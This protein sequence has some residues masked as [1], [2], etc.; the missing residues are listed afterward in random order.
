MKLYNIL[1]VLAVLILAGCAPAENQPPEIAITGLQSEYIVGTDVMYSVGATDDAGLVS[2]TIG[3]QH[4]DESGTQTL[5]A[6]P[7]FIDCEGKRTCTHIVGPFTSAETGR[8]VI[9]A[10]ALDTDGA[11]TD[12]SVEYTVTK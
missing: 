10:S 4:F 11:Q 8:S 1:P 9:L 7:E 12:I 6:E 3:F 2:M 5:I